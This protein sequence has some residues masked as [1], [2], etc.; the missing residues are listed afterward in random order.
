M[1]PNQDMEFHFGLNFASVNVLDNTTVMFR[2]KVNVPEQS[3]NTE[4]LFR[5]PGKTFN[6]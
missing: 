3:A 5:N 6:T 2:V 4:C 1:P